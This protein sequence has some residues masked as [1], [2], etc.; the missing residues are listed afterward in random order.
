MRKT[1][2]K[3]GGKDC[4]D[5]CCTGGREIIRPHTDITAAAAGW[6]PQNQHN[7]DDVY[8]HSKREGWGGG[9]KTHNRHT[10]A[11]N[12]TYRQVDR[13]GK[14]ADSIVV[15]LGPLLETVAIYRTCVGVCRG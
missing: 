9:K 11:R 7:D 4:N 6:C 2:E 8:L 14:E 10:L 5:T 1:V 15:E 13:G 3:T 12:T